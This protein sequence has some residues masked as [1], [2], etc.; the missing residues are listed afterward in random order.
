MSKAH[1]QVI[2]AEPSAGQAS[3]AAPT[4]V[5]DYELPA[6]LMVPHCGKDAMLS[7]LEDIAAAASQRIGV[8]L[9][10][11]DPRRTQ[12]FVESQPNLAH[13]SILGA[14]YDSPWIRDRAP[15]AM[16]RGGQV[17]W[18]LPKLPPGKRRLDAALFTNISVRPA[19]SAELT[20]A[21]GNLIAGPHGIAVST[22]RILREN[23]FSDAQQ[24]A[25]FAPGLGIRRWLV[26]KSFPDEPA[27]HA[28]VHVRFLREDLFAVGWSVSDSA[29]EERARD[30]E[31]GVKA[32]VP[33]ARGL[34]IP[35]ARDG[36]RYASLLNWIQIGADLLVPT[37]DL[38][39]D[40][41]LAQA[42]EILGA[43]G[44][45]VHPIF[46]PTLDYGGSLHCLTASVFV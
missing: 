14:T 39:S 46:S 26:F 34:R 30:I 12:T 1:W 35:I 3:G 16:R 18:V 15:I 45:R 8:I 31:D 43:A 28:D 2:D 42:E 5:P 7:L 6:A 4:L 17:E 23:K 38:T 36:S 37:Y 40:K 21:Q 29:V 33:N 41:A 19:H 11:D 13:F 20:L 10:S 27:Q 9:L 24:M 44:F 32:V 25:A 22:D